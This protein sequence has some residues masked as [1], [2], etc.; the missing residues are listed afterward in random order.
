MTLREQMAADLAALHA[1][2]SGAAEDVVYHKAG[3]T[4]LDFRMVIRKTGISQRAFDDG[5]FEVESAV[6]IVEKAEL[7][8]VTFQDTITAEDDTVW[9]VTALGAENTA[10]FELILTRPVRKQLIGPGGRT[11]RGGAA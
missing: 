2:T 6:G 3:G 10:F 4:D 9:S 8:A 11:P 7:D 1:D 5:L